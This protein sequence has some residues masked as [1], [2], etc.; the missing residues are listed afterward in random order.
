MDGGLLLDV[1]I[2]NCVSSL[3]LLP[4]KDQ[5]LLVRRDSLLAMDLGLHRINGIRRLN[6]HSERLS[7]ESLDEDLHVCVFVE[8]IKEAIVEEKE[9][10]KKCE[11]SMKRMGN[12]I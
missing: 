12:D 4:S 2:S 8:Q 1:V 10:E 9:E 7:S 3:E 6:I 11:M 5:T